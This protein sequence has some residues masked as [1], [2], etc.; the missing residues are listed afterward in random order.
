[1]YRGGVTV[2]A[3]EPAAAAV[4][5]RAGFL[6]VVFGRPLELDGRVKVDTLVPGLGGPETVPLRGATAFRMALPDGMEPTVTRDGNTW[7]I[8]LGPRASTRPEGLPVDAQRDF[9][10]GARLVVGVPDARQ[11][12]QINDPVVGDQLLVVPLPNPGQ[13]VADPHGFS[14]LR[15]LPAAQGIVVQP[16]EDT[17]AVRPIR[18]GVEVTSAGGLRLSPP[19]DL[20]G[21]SATRLSGRG[22]EPAAT[23]RVCSISPSGGAARPPNSTSSV[24]RRS[25][26]CSRRPR[27]NATARGWTSP[28]STSPMVWRRKA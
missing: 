12:I 22:R 9:P 7:R 27:S 11:V 10:L 4:Y 21:V 15:L 8:G 6:Y 18:D 19:G 28:I 3:Q 24:S 13:A 1:M 2:E 25:R 16:L 20:T 17:V 14:Q 26:P 5:T 23:S